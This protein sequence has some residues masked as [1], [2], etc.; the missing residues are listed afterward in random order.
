[1]TPEER[2][3]AAGLRGRWYAI[4]GS[5]NVAER[6]VRVERMGE[7][8]VLWR[9][10]VGTLHAQDDRCPHRGARL[11][12]GRVLDDTIA[13]PYHGVMIDAA[14]RIAKV[15]AL[16]GC[17]LEGRQ[18]VRTFATHERGGLIFAYFPSPANEQPIPFAGPPE[19][20]DPAWSFFPIE[21]T[22][23]VN[24]RYVMENV[25]DPMH[26]PYLHGDSH[27]MSVGTKEDVIQVDETAQGFRV[28]R[29]LQQDT[30]LD[31]IELFDPGLMWLRLDIPYSPQVGPGGPFRILGFATPIDE[32]R[33]HIFFWRLRHVAGWERDLWRFLH[34]NRLAARHWAVLEQDRTLLEQLPDDANARETLYQHDIG[35]TRF[36]RYLRALARAQLEAAREP[37]LQPA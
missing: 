6:P 16:P 7:Q 17:P 37:A 25:L 4:T 12:Q 11:S 27:S 14:G 2:I 29:K 13:C 21:T 35:V 19:L 18:A 26:G 15:P 30:A 10:A 22:W 31:S 3:V 32:R 20:S 8:L 34:R 24:W 5:Q 33:S 36:R 28:W 1:M 23:N 9:D